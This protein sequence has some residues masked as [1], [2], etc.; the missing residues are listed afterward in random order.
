MDLRVD[1]QVGAAAFSPATERSIALCGC[2][3]S[4]SQC[5][6]Q[7]GKLLELFSFGEA[8]R[9]IFVGGVQRPEAVAFDLGESFLLREWC[10]CARAEEGSN[11]GRGT[12]LGLSAV[13]H[14]DMESFEGHRG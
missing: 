9:S 8:S 13:L 10:A 1:I 3:T 11:C 6:A 7:R 12:H 4:T 2:G 5:L 14:D